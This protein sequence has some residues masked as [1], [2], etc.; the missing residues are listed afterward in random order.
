MAMIVSNHVKMTPLDAA[1]TLHGLRVDFIVDSVSIFQ[2]APLMIRTATIVTQVHDSH[3]NIFII[4]LDFK[5][6]I[7]IHYNAIL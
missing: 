1:T 2:H 3:Y 7:R 4:A 5:T 6:C